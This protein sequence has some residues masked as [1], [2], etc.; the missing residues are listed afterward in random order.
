MYK[1][2]RNSIVSL[3]RRSKTNHFSRYFDLHSKNMHKIWQGVRD[4]ISLKS[5]GQSRPISLRINGVLSSN[6]LEVA[7]E[8]NSYFTSILNT[9]RI[10]IPPSSKH[11]SSFLNQPNPNSI[12]L[13]PVRPRE[14]LGIIIQCL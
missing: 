6:P 4:I 7:S 14:I 3:C 1:R 11:F 10:R 5:S 13:S 8:F 9:I 12:F 2:Y